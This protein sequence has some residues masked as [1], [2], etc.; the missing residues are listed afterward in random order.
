MLAQQ[1]DDLFSEVNL[2]ERV[3]VFN[4]SLPMEWL[5]EALTLTETVTLRRRKLPPEQVIRLVV[6]MSL[7]RNESIQEVATRL[8][9]SSKGLDN[10][11]LSAR[12][13]LSEARQRV[14]K[15]PVRT[16]FEKSADHWASQT[17]VDDNWHGLE[18]FAIDG[19]TLRTEDTPELRE[20]FGSANTSGEFES[21][22][23]VMQLTCLMNVR[24]HI[25]LRAQAG[26][27]RESE[28][29]QTTKML[30]S[31][32]DNSVLLMDKL[33]HCAKLLLELETKGNNRFWVTPI[34]KDLKYEMKHSYAKNDYLVERDLSSARRKDKTLPTRWDMRLVTYETAN[35]TTIKLATNL[36]QEKYSA[37]DIVALYKER[38]EIELGYREVKTSMLN[39]AITLRSKK[40]DLV[41]QELYGMLIAYN[42]VRHEIVL[43]ADNVGL[44]PTRISFKSCLRIVL[45]DYAITASTNSLHTIPARMKDLTDVLKDFIL[46]EP[47]R[48]DYPRVVKI[49]PTKFPLKKVERLRKKP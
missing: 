8:A 27:Y 3:D 13:S 42:L 16:L 45:Y 39:K 9:F 20:H 29:Y 24:S 31:V 4:A 43:T 41:Y 6:G 33:Y 44:R 46:P 7:L 5:E 22:Y 18:P 28:L 25:I 40:V 19:T 2:Q 34:R 26:K 23:P 48:P 38:W 30:D 10:G 1:L 17:H 12:S 36:P 32:P 14:G 37:A 49:K 11:L 47:D 21:G 15:A 35:G